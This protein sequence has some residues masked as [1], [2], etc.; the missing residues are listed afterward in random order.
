V[1]HGVALTNEDRAT[2]DRFHRRFIDGGVGLKFQST[3]RPPQS[4]Y[5]SY[6]ELL[7]ARD[8]DGQPGNYLAA[9]SSFQFIKDLQ[10]RNLVI[11]V[12]GDISGPR[13]VGAVGKHLAARKEQVSVFYTS[14]VEFYLFNSGR[15]PAFLDN[16]SR[17]PRAPKSVI[18]RSFFQRYAWPNAGSASR[19]QPMA[20]LLDGFEKGRFR[21]YS[22]LMDAAGR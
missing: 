9:E 13:A 4:H 20:E 2:I 12:V 7:L 14:N 5:P 21:Y 11:P 19:L 1:K 6:R 22:D 10:H 16:L 3:G 18:I 8:P 15:F 17:L